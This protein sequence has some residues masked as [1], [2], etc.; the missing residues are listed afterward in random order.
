MKMDFE[1]ALTYISK[2]KSWPKKL[3]LGACILFSAFAV[4]IIPFVIGLIAHSAVGMLISVVIC[5]VI[6]MI[7]F[8]SLSGYV[9]VSANNTIRK[10][11]ELLPEWSHFGCLILVGM[12]YFA[13]YFIYILPVLI[14]GFIFS[15]IFGLSIMNGHSYSALSGSIMFLF[16]TLFGAVTFFLYILTA[17][18]LPLMMTNFAKDLKILSFIDVKKAFTMLNNNIGNYFVLIL[19]FIAIGVLGQIVCWFLSLTVIGLV[20]VPVLYFYLYLVVA[21]IMAQFAVVEEIED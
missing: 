4:F 10:E 11:D 20:L 15:L 19:L 12:K 17:I 14:S 21:N 8:L 1:K 9:L 3:L 2:D 16:L 18:F 13:G 6:S 5:S 7:L